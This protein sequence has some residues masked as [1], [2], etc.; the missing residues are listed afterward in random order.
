MNLGRLSFATIIGP[1]VAAA[2]ALCLLTSGCSEPG[3]AR[4]S[5]AT[6]PASASAPS[7]APA[8]APSPV[9]TSAS[10]GAVSVLYD[11][12]KPEEAPQD[13]RE[14]V[15][16]GHNLMTE[17][18]KYAPNYVGNE[19]ACTNCHFNGGIS[20][21]GRNG[22]IPL[23]GVGATYPRYQSRHNYSVDLVMRTQDCF[24]RSMNGKAPPSD[25]REMQSIVAYYQWISKGIPVYATVPWLGL[26]K[27]ESSHQGDPTAGK[28]VF[29]QKCATCH[30]ADGQG[31]PAAPPTW[32]SNSFND[33]AGMYSAQTMAA[34][35]NMNMPRGNPDLTVE[36]ALD[37]A[38]YIVQ[39]P[40]PHHQQ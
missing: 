26:K 17:T 4:T 32:G 1:A 10:R 39:Q 20:Q 33:G 16:L 14:A 18:K 11:P 24:Q 28:Q 9:P 5:E 12:P 8:S 36:Q 35:V 7:A 27:L 25:S 38:S 13:I 37:V 30:G 40:R 3:A 22:G 6:R 23:V 31:T 2:A 15:L 21:G 29:D 34:F 19:L